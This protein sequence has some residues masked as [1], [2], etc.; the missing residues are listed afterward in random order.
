MPTIPFFKPH[1]VLSHFINAEGLLL[2]PVI[3]AEVVAL[4][5]DADQFDGID[6]IPAPGAG[7][8]V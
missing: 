2:L 4:V 1:S 7:R 3:I 8:L 6:L 5:L